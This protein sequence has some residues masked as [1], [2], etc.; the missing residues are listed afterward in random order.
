MKLNQ[1]LEAL[2]PEHEMD[3]VRQT[4]KNDITDT[5]NPSKHADLVLSKEWKEK[6]DRFLDRHPEAKAMFAK[7]G[8]KREYQIRFPGVVENQGD[9]E[10]NF[11]VVTEILEAFQKIPNQIL[12]LQELA[13]EHAKGYINGDDYSKM[14]GI[15]RCYKSPVDFLKNKS[16]RLGYISG[17]LPIGKWVGAPGQDRKVKLVMMSIG[18]VLQQMGVHRSFIEQFQLDPIRIGKNKPYDIIITGH[19]IDIY[20]ASTGRG[21]TSCA[22]LFPEHGSIFDQKHI[23]MSDDGDEQHDY[24]PVNA[25][26]HIGNDINNHVHMAY[27]VPS[28]GDID[29]D[30]VARVSY[31]L[32]TKLGGIGSTLL[33]ENRV[34]GQAPKEFLQVANDLVKQIFVVEDGFYCQHPDSYVDTGARIKKVGKS[35]PT[36]DVLDDAAMHYHELTDDDEQ[37]A[38]MSTLTKQISNLDE[39]SFTGLMESIRSRKSTFLDSIA[40]D[41]HGQLGN[42]IEG[43]ES[44][45]STICDLDS[46][47]EGLDTGEIEPSFYNNLIVGVVYSKYFRKWWFS[48][49]M[50]ENCVHGI[51]EHVLDEIE[52]DGNNNTNADDI[53]DYL[54]TVC[55]RH[56]NIKIKLFDHFQR[57]NSSIVRLL[58]YISANYGSLMACLDVS[59]IGI[60]SHDHLEN[61]S[62]MMLEFL[63]QVHTDHEEVPESIVK[64]MN[65]L[66]GVMNRFVKQPYTLLDW[67]LYLEEHHGSEHVSETGDMETMRDWLEQMVYEMFPNYVDV[68]DDGKLEFLNKNEDQFAKFYEKLKDKVAGNHIHKII[69]LIDF[70]DL[71]VNKLMT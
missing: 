6:R 24:E 7:G 48:T 35:V 34:Y 33:S 30:A 18:K 10:L 57:A 21:W 52:Y 51:F 60:E 58:A 8:E 71:S 66:V 46:F 26:A 12:D 20:G 1:I 5:S 13:D 63:K 39:N 41:E 22:N 45:T 14:V 19:P 25:A 49:P 61:A 4:Y 47:A 3:A 68:T 38:F 55:Y 27:L 31:K 53:F 42:G 69:D 59:E 29:H 70:G 15:L 62:Y 17:V 40:D 37:D 54:N 11:T 64:E 28:G 65:G 56:Q 67:L 23:D 9:G 2:R 16:M 44:Y 32:H 50:F 36:V 43:I